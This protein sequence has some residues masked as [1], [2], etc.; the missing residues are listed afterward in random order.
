MPFTHMRLAAARGAF[1]GG[2]LLDGTLWVSGG[3]GGT[4]GYFK[5][6]WSL[7]LQEDVPSLPPAA[8]P[9]PPPEAFGTQP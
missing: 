8:P 4:G 2:A 7:S 3:Y 9:P 1:G 5:D 6:L